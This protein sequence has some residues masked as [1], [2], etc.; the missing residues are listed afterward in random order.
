MARKKRPSKRNTPST[1]DRLLPDIQDLIKDLRAKGRTIDEIRAKL[2]ELDVDVSRSALGRHVKSLADMQARM[3]DSHAMAQALAQ[4]HGDKPVNDLANANFQLMHSLVMQT[5]TAA[6]VDPE[7][8]EAMPV[9]FNAQE[10]MFLAKSLQ[11]LASAQKA[12]QD[13]LVKAQEEAREEERRRAV[14]RVEEAAKQ[15]GF[16]KDMV[17]AI[18]H[19]VLGT[20]S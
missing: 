17:T 2:F 9:T 13:R 18:R 16:S 14:G 1:I 12:N 15:Q 7:T 11:S 19:A 3:R 20:T 8:G 4:Q 6:E 10:A 5:M